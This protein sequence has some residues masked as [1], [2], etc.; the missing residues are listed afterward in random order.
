MP[1]DS[2]GLH[3]SPIMTLPSI[4]EVANRMWKRMLYPELDGVMM[5][6]SL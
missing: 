4:I 3:P 6:L 2:D 5:M 1:Q